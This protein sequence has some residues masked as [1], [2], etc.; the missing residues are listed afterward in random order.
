MY[1]LDISAKFLLNMFLFE[2]IY[3]KLMYF[4][5]WI[6]P[7]KPEP[8]KLAKSA[9]FKPSNDFYPEYYAWDARE[10]IHD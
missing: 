2:Y 8:A 10:K 5:A 4:L 6:Y 7:I 1:K 9:L 3:E